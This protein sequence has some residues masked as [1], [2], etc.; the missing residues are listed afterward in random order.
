MAGAEHDFTYFIQFTQVSFVEPPYTSFNL[1]VLGGDIS[2]MPFLESFLAST[3]RAV[4]A[5]YTLPHDYLI[6]LVAGDLPEDK[7]D[8]PVGILRVTLHAGRNIPKTDVF[9]HCDPF[10]E[11]GPN[12][13]FSS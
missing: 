2:T 11:C 3:L 7:A 12:S 6:P 1:R 10:V 4:L 5:P 9:T 13:H 8:A